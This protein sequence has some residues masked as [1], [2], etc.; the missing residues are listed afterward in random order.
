M[1]IGGKPVAAKYHLSATGCEMVQRRV[2]PQT[3]QA[4][5]HVRG[6]DDRPN[7]IEFFFILVIKLH[8]TIDWVDLKA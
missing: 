6:F 3:L 8:P 4:T 2:G 7:F 5:F 1:Q